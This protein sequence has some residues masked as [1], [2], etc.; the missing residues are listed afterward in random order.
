MRSHRLGRFFAL[1]FLIY[2]TTT[3]FSWG[4]K[5]G[6]V[7]PDFV[8]SKG[9]DG[10][11]VKLSDFYGQSNVILNTVQTA[12]SPD[13]EFASQ[14]QSQAEAFKAKYD[15]VTITIKSESSEVERTLFIIDKS[16]HIRWKFDGKADADH[17]TVEQLESELGKLK[18]TTPLPL[19]S[20]A[21]D[22]SL[23]EADGKTIFTLSDYKGKKNVLV[24]LLLQ[25]Y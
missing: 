1:L 7:P 25:T 6:D 12:S 3:P 21:P 20:P 13:S 16:G 4:L 22:F 17:P 14:L 11:E 8:V 24:T 15:A 2:L 18:R 5:V 19:G 9:A 23:T 10:E